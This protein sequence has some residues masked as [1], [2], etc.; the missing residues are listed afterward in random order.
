MKSKFSS[1]KLNNWIF[2]TIGIFIFIALSQVKCTDSNA[3][4]TTLN[5]P[6]TTTIVKKWDT[7]NIG[8]GSKREQ[9]LLKNLTTIMGKK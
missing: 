5:P 3:T 6:T 7:C 4:N 2:S 9:D 1:K 8:L